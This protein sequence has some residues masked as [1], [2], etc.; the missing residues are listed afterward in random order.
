MAVDRCYESQIPTCLQRCARSILKL[1]YSH[2]ESD[3][4][5]GSVLIP[6]VG[7]VGPQLHQKLEGCNS[8]DTCSESPA[9]AI[10]TQTPI[11]P[12]NHP[13]G[14]GS[15]SGSAYLLSSP[16]AVVWHPPSARTRAPTAST[17]QRQAS[18]TATWP[19]VS[20]V[21]VFARLPGHSANSC[22][23]RA[24]ADS[25]VTLQCMCLARNLAASAR[26]PQRERSQPAARGQPV[27]AAPLRQR[28]RTSLAKVHTRYTPG[29][30]EAGSSRCT[31]VGSRCRRRSSGAM[32][33]ERNARALRCGS[34]SLRRCRRAST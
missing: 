4:N 32:S 14:C 9:H 18:A 8:E 24:A 13:S 2:H 30:S 16:F 5:S 27:R 34:A 12:R 15:A 17:G 20:S 11:R 26:L 29:V 21:P 6:P 25:L 10:P 7:F 31:R 28:R 19:T 23:D 33:D 3:K 1:D 22:P